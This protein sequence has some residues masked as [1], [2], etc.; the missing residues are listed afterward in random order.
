MFCAVSCSSDSTPNAR[1]TGWPSLAE[2]VVVRPASLET[3]TM[4]LKRRCDRL[5]ARKP[6]ETPPRRAMRSLS[7]KRPTSLPV[8]WAPASL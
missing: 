3:K 8:V 7:S 5:G 6:V 1:A 4:E 2:K